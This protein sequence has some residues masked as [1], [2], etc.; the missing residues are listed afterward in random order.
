M[1]NSLPNGQTIVPH[2]KF[3]ISNYGKSAASLRRVQAKF[4]MLE[5]PLTKE[6]A[7]GNNIKPGQTQISSWTNS[8][9]L[10][11]GETIETDAFAVPKTIRIDEYQGYGRPSLDTT[12]Q[13]FLFV[14]IDYEDLSSDAWNGFTCWKYERISN[15]IFARY[16]GKEWN[17]EQ[18]AN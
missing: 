15:G 2:V 1:P 7:T 10:R 9:V 16:G 17:H 14:T 4:M 13:L 3:R 8:T 12:A 5:L 18:K 11:P 6:Q